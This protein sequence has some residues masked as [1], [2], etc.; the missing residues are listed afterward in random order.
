MNITLAVS[1]YPRGELPRFT[2]LLPRLL[3]HY[4]QVVISFIPRQGNR[5]IPEFEAGKFASYPNLAYYVNKLQA[6]GRYMA[7]KIALDYPADFIHYADMDR[8]L[9]WVETRP[10]EWQEI[11]GCIPQ[12]EAIIFGRTPAAYETHPQ[13]LITTEQL[14][15]QLVSQFLDMPMDVSA[16]SKSFS[17]RAAQYLVEHGSPDDSIGSDAEWPILLKRAGFNLAYIPV[18]GLDWETADHFQAQ[19]ATREEQREAARS[20]DA[21]AAHWRQRVEIAGKIIQAALATNQQMIPAA[22]NET[23]GSVEFDFQAVF[24]VDDYL[25]FY[26]ES[27][28]DERTDTEVRALV[29]LLELDKPLKILDL[30]CGF[31]RHANRLAALGHTLT[32]VD[33]TPGFL[34]IARKDARD[35]GVRVAYLQGDMRTIEFHEEFD[36]VMLLF[37]AFGYFSDE[38]NQQVLV[39]IARALK[40]GGLL[41]FDSHNRDAFLKEMHPCFVMEK[42]GNLMI[43]RLSFD[44]Q[45]GRWY[46]HRIVIRDGV[47]K[48]KPFFVRLYNLSELKSMLAQAGLELHHVYASWDAREFTADARRLVVL[49][50]KPQGSN[51]HEVPDR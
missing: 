45:S 2:R 21:D 26:Q 6:N 44:G 10:G 34:D 36:R 19:A 28:T 29:G 35:R 42:E 14:S 13:A 8:L 38:Q 5:I 43:D 32:G 51:H 9:R 48:D 49:A 1:W 3:E 39:R 41:I 15:N 16:G 20:Y 4:A 23:A 24:E 11:L 30:A 37:T 18:E 7:L 12:H 46:N 22:R 25:Y 40:P 50:R 17:R 27:L 33:L 31:G 47:R